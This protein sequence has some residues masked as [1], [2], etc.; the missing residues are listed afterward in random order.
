V[1]HKPG[2]LHTITEI[3]YKVCASWSLNRLPRKAYLGAKVM[4]LFLAIFL[5][6]NANIQNGLHNLPMGILS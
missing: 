5:K 2:S 3:P 6:N 4:K 1:S